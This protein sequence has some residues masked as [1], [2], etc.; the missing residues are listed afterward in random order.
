[1]AL[2]RKFLSALGI[3]GDK[4]D[5]I[6]NA[7]SETVEA[8]KEERDN[9]RKEADGFK[10]KAN[11]A[12][13]LQKELDALKTEAEKN[14][15]N[16]WKIKY[17]AM[18]EERNKIKADFDTFKNE[19]SAKETKA[20]KERAYR[21]IL[22]SAGV[23]EKRIDSI[24]KVTDID[25]V[26]LDESGNVKDESKAIESIKT[27][28]ADFITTDGI[29]GANTATPPANDSSNNNT[30]GSRAAK[31]AAAFHNNLYGENPK[32]NGKED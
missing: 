15:G 16:A 24:I 17:D 4:V 27:E 14:G 12:D 23:S 32:S 8:L 30:Q 28:W 5:E 26:E 21:A 13:T 2:T 9:A 18:V 6:I 11:N 3:E 7:H 20:S 10:A 19:T 1:M 31:I 22:K 29:Q 25:K